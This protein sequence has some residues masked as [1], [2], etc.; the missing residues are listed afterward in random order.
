[1]RILSIIV[2]LFGLMPQAAQA[3]SQSDHKKVVKSA[4]GALSLPSSFCGR[5]AA[6]AYNVDAYEFDDMAAHAQRADELT[7]CQGADKLQE[8]VR[9]LGNQ[10]RA[11]VLLMKAS[12]SEDTA[13]AIA[14]LLGRLM[15]TIHDNCV[16]EG[17]GN[18]Q[19]GF[20]SLSD[21]C[22]DTEIS[23][24][25]DPNGLTCSA[26]ETTAALN[27]FKQLLSRVGL[28]GSSLGVSSV[29][30][31]WP[32]RGPVCSYLRSAYSWDGV[33]I[34]W[35]AAVMIPHIRAQLAHSLTVDDASIDSI[36]DP[37]PAYLDPLW[38]DPPVDVDNVELDWCFT[39]SVY[40]IGKADDL[41][42]E[43]PPY[44]PE[45]TTEG[46]TGL[47]EGSTGDGGCSTG[48][49]SGGDGALFL[50]GLAGLLLALGRTRKN[51]R[52]TR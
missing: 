35:D 20:A 15:H 5:V 23:P 2:F 10:V 1:M 52:P 11:Q 12:P 6:G 21:T 45:E 13:E 37:D 28:S 26:A 48:G 22:E 4:C 14:D 18:P 16:H 42:D 31:H 9:L 51:R 38:I 39:V 34:R 30:T 46:R 32:T 17:V 33:D 47:D 50:F 29:S 8:R 36:C 19:H 49:R 27:S 24:D 40:C 44:T 41:T 25:L 7:L 43:P 3:L